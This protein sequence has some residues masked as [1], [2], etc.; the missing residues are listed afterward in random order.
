[1]H[2]LKALEEEVYLVKLCSRK[3]G[4]A[5]EEQ[6]PKRNTGVNITAVRTF[7]RIETQTCRDFAHNKKW[8]LF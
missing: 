1:M 2:L 5:A 4:A 3:I 7:V 6:K 8:N